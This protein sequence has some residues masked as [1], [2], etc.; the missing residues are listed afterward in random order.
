MKNLLTNPTNDNVTIKLKKSISDKINISLT[1]L[2][3]RKIK[4]LN[5]DKAENKIDLFVKDLTLGYYLL[6]T[7]TFYVSHSLKLFVEK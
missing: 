4:Q 7:H 6:S 1:D 5:F 2:L 3:G